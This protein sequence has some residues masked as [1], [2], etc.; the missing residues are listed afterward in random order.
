MGVCQ[1]PQI[2]SQYGSAVAF[3]MRR[4]DS[5]LLTDVGRTMLARRPPNLTVI[6]GS[7]RVFE[8]LYLR[9][10]AHYYKAIS[11]LT[12]GDLCGLRYLDY[13][14]HSYTTTVWCP[15][16]GLVEVVEAYSNTDFTMV[17]KKDY[18]A[19]FPSLFIV[20]H[21]PVQTEK[22]CS[23]DRR[24]YITFCTPLEHLTA[25]H[26]VRSAIRFADLLGIPRPDTT[27]VCIR[28]LHLKDHSSRELATTLMG[29][30]CCCTWFY[31][32]LFGLPIELAAHICSYSGFP[33]CVGYFAA[34]ASRKVG[35][36]NNPPPYYP[37]VC[38]YLERLGPTMPPLAQLLAPT[39]PA[40]GHRTT[41][42]DRLRNLLSRERE[43]HKAARRRL[44]RSIHVWELP[45]TEQ[46]GG[47]VEKEPDSCSTDSLPAPPTPIDQA[48]DEVP[49][50][51]RFHSRRAIT[52]LTT[53]SCSCEKDI[54]SSSNTLYTKA[55][56]GKERVPVMGL[57][58]ESALWSST[59]L[60]PIPPN[61]VR[62]LPFEPFAMTVKD[63]AR[64]I[65]QP[66]PLLAPIAAVTEVMR[67]VTKE[68]E[69]QVRDQIRL[70]KTGPEAR[71]TL[72]EQM[73]KRVQDHIVGQNNN[74]RHWDQDPDHILDSEAIDDPMPCLLQTPAAKTTPQAASKG[75]T[76][77][78][79]G[80]SALQKLLSAVANKIQYCYTEL[81]TAARN[82]LHL[83]LEE[84]KAVGRTSDM[85]AALDALG[86]VLSE[87]ESCSSTASLD[88]HADWF[89]AQF[90]PSLTSELH[91]KL[92]STFDSMREGFHQ[93]TKP[94]NNLWALHERWRHSPE[95]CMTMPVTEFSTPS[96]EAP[97]PTQPAYGP[98]VKLAQFRQVSNALTMNVDSGG[99]TYY[100][101]ITFLG[102]VNKLHG[103]LH[104]VHTYDLRHKTNVLLD[105]LAC[106]CFG[107]SLLGIWRAEWH[108][109]I[110]EALVNARARVTD[111]LPLG[112]TIQQAVAWCQ[113]CDFN[114][115]YLH[116]PEDPLAPT[117]LIGCLN[118]VSKHQPMLVYVPA[119]GQ[120]GI[121]HWI[122]A[123]LLK[124]RHN[125]RVALGNDE[126]VIDTSPA[127]IPKKV[128][129]ASDTSTTPREV[130]GS[131]PDIDPETH[132]Y[133]WLQRSVR[134]AIPAPPVV[135]HFDFVCDCENAL[136]QDIEDAEA[137]QFESIERLFAHSPLA[138][139]PVVPL[140][141][142]NL[143]RVVHCR[144]RTVP[145]V[146]GAELMGFGSARW[147]KIGDA[148]EG[149]PSFYTES[150][151]P[152][153]LDPLLLHAF[154][155]YS[156]VELRDDCLIGHRIGARTLLF[157]RDQAAGVEPRLLED[158]SWN[159]ATVMT[160]ECEGATYTLCRPLVTAYG[161]HKYYVYPL[162]LTAAGPEATLMNMLP[163]SSFEVK[164][165]GFYPLD[166]SLPKLADIAGPTDDARYRAAYLLYALKMP[167]FLQPIITD[168]RNEEQYLKRHTGIEPF[169]VARSIM[170]FA[171]RLPSKPAFGVTTVPKHC[172]CC[173]AP[174]PAKYRWRRR[175]C[176]DCESRLA[177]I[178]SVSVAGQMIQA[179]LCVPSV[180]PGIVIRKGVELPPP[181]KKWDGVRLTDD[182]G[183]PMLW[184]CKEALIRKKG[185]RSGNKKYE[186]VDK[187]FLPR[188]KNMVNTTNNPALGGVGV[189]GCYP[190]ISAKTPYNCFKAVAGRIFRQPKAAPID[191]I[192]N[193]LD[194][195]VPVLLPG[196]EAPL[197]TFDEWLT[198][199]PSHRR[200]PLLAAHQKY[201]EG[202]WKHKY[203]KF[204]AFV[205]QEMLPD[206]SKRDVEDG[207]SGLDLHAIEEYVDRLI[208][209]PHDVTHTIAGRKLKPLVARLKEIWHHDWPIFYGSVNPEKLQA[210]LEQLEKR[211]GL[212]VWC[213][214][215]M[216][217]NTHSAESWAFMERLYRA[218]GEVPM[219]FD[220]VMAAWKRP[221]GVCGPFKYSAPKVVNAS[222]RD[223]T[224][225]ANGVLN[226]F[227][228]FLS[229]TAAWL[230]KPLLLL[231][232][233]DVSA[234]KAAL[235]LSV[236][237]DDSLGSVPGVNDVD[238]FCATVKAN[239]AL[240]G[241]E[242]KFCASYDITDCV[243][244]AKRPYYSDSGVSWGLT[245]GRAIYKMGWTI[246]KANEDVLAK[247]T[248]IAEMH[249]LCSAN[250]PILSDVAERIVELRKGCRR[251]P[252][253]VDPN[254]PWTMPI[255]R[256]KYDQTTKEWLLKTYTKKATSCSLYA[257]HAS[258]ITM[259]SLDNLL[260]EIRLIP[261]LP[262]V[263]D[264][265]LL[266][267]IV[268]LD[269]L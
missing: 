161:P 42:Q 164:A 116:N 41:T 205:K 49:V 246:A 155:A 209:G 129:R 237:G 198:T 68:V 206:I 211:A 225:L 178:G 257:M 109:K 130:G 231:T 99:C 22:F 55:E 74:N 266:R 104:S 119:D 192:Y 39:A 183:R 144:S 60:P 67:L 4:H 158:G 29:Y 61:M 89:D 9:D 214:Y 47:L 267:L 69:C 83:A 258:L 20:N 21:H 120:D 234:A 32:A 18:E 75:E 57:E 212:F 59:N 134:F 44:E 117:E 173:G 114:I 217:D 210:W 27:G 238:R 8:K 101:R 77:I 36:C 35:Y 264:N 189:A 71:A 175:I 195:F 177:A 90:G 51:T 176:G 172:S 236:C 6:T 199:M 122:P 66:V 252:V 152:E 141:A 110:A 248:G 222:G 73:A 105:S 54:P 159:P 13:P 180:S 213:D 200:R 185:V 131:Q 121:A 151:V 123:Y 64:P 19:H 1:S 194:Q 118:Q 78:D 235:M 50:I 240:F 254:R 265:E 128:K 232:P 245:I 65:P 11:T 70:G 140:N 146:T 107:L 138:Q 250:V 193:W 113:D 7:P 62:D 203:S 249:A 184:V 91:Q 127:K 82:R 124:S 190:F 179:G 244:L 253:P 126:Q 25:H 207:G 187:D 79:L 145:P 14:V 255:A 125:V 170:E 97:R 56:K 201:L 45:S 259:Q 136:R 218:A 147:H 96:V 142:V 216:F 149:N 196:F 12:M 150:R 132:D 106:S 202:G 76:A 98:R 3:A 43:K 16:E 162:H 63:C 85:T 167:T 239:L 143:T 188:I 17:A 243:Y 268:H 2:G 262:F 269:E 230:D 37:P 160:I 33:T 233:E 229:L 48:L 93:L 100:D 94:I 81:S 182:R 208:N 115:A 5:T 247:I 112:V 87:V 30:N 24:D 34:Y 102:P 148:S 28:Y 174:P 166:R 168:C 215:T 223:D 181:A 226:G 103:F 169:T 186:P 58:E 52:G 80:P 228:M 139:G 137:E 221:T 10:H 15:H 191:G 53:S 197:M 156:L 241:F 46:Y 242:G 163:F 38:H 92:D 251:T 261:I 23:Q 26:A 111:G 171:D 204:K 31:A 157:V 133:K 86:C 165:V 263:L 88:V 220:R 224:A 72:I 108:I 154:D 95:V 84:Y 260:N 135:K 40:Y 219:D 256:R 153:A 227:A